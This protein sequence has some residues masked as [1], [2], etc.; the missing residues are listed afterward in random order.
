MTK[1]NCLIFD[2]DSVDGGNFAFSLQANWDQIRK[3]HIHVPELQVTQI[4]DSGEALRFLQTPS[5]GVQLLF[6]DVLVPDKTGKSQMT[7][8]LL[9]REAKK[10]PFVPVVIAITKG[11][12]E[13]QRGD[14]FGKIE[15]SGADWLIEKLPFSDAKKGNEITEEVLRRLEKVGLLK[16]RGKL[17]KEIGHEN[18]P[19]LAAAFEKIEESNLSAFANYF[20]FN[21]TA[22]NV[23][24]SALKRGLS[25]ADVLAARYSSTTVDLKRNGVLIK[26]SRDGDSLKREFENYRLH[27][28]S[29]RSFGSTLIVDF[30]Q[31]K[32][33]YTVNGW[34]AIAGKFEHQATTVINW[35]SELNRSEAQVIAF[36]DDLFID[37]LTETYK[38]NAQIV[39]G[40]AISTTIKYLLGGH[41]KISIKNAIV[42]LGPLIKKYH[43]DFELFKVEKLV[44]MQEL[45]SID[46]SKL[47][48]RLTMTIQ[49]GDFHASNVLVISK[50]TKHRPK[51][52][53]YANI[54]MLP[55]ATDIVRF[56]VDVVLTCI[57][58]G[59][60]SYEWLHLDDWVAQIDV[61][62]FG[63]QSNVVAS[64]PA[65]ANLPALTVLNWITKNLFTVVGLTDTSQHR[66]EYLMALGIEFMR[67]A[68]R[69]DEL[70]APKR[71]LGLICGET[72]LMRAETEF[73]K[74]KNL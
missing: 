10:H 64:A 12:D 1:I 50:E 32:Q 3:S 33:P 13:N 9:I 41:R 71:A 26:I 5:N 46:R 27:I 62:S 65:P 44:T 59:I 63:N 49:H 21:E 34:T 31:V 61:V 23:Y 53:D 69:K 6:C 55:W 74:T 20:C 37:E 47:Y 35:L 15:S 19:N 52:I 22:D 8:L 4:S 73:L 2:D 43:R 56:V 38:A 39:E 57:D 51:I 42:E 58:N 25:G 48:K 60:A 17:Q 18:N 66:A 7:G 28:V 16:Y 14:F 67:A 11:P 36:L 45:G 24:L 54:A 29:K 72:A 68:Y 40:E 70:A 30:L